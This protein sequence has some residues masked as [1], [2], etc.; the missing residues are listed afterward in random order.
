MELQLDA[1]DVKAIQK[2]HIPIQNYLDAIMIRHDMPPTKHGYHIEGTGEEGS[3][4]KLVPTPAP[5]D[6]K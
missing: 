3:P 6:S 2:L 1:L 4:M 5:K